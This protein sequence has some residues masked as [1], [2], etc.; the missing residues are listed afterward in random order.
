MLKTN[1]GIDITL[2]EELVSGATGVAFSD[3]IDFHQ[4]GVINHK[5][6]T[7]ELPI[8]GDKS[9]VLG[10]KSNSDLKEDELVKVSG[11]KDIVFK[12]SG[13][14]TVSETAAK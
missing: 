12:K 13:E 5:E 8:V 3:S 4:I 10:L 11:K 14:V 2:T 6:N 7:I 9:I 1:G